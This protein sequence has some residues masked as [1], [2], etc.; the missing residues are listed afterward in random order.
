MSIEGGVDSPNN[1]VCRFYIFCFLTSN[2]KHTLFVVHM[3]LCPFQSFLIIPQARD[4]KSLRCVSFGI[5]T[6]L[7]M[8]CTIDLSE[9]GGHWD[10]L[11]QRSSFVLIAWT[12]CVLMLS[13]SKFIVGMPPPLLSLS[14][15]QIGLV[16]CIWT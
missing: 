11:S 7:K 3:K 5:A 13:W 4:C 6:P 16:N 8:A 15:D 2:T 12:W 1:P 14:A 10:F 9:M